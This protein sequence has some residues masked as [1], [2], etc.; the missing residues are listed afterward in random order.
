M[1]LILIL[2]DVEVE[3]LKELVFDE[4]DVAV[5]LRMVDLERSDD[6]KRGKSK[7]LT[8]GTR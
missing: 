8:V 2:R 1:I 3:F 7:I 4:L 5:I 6:S